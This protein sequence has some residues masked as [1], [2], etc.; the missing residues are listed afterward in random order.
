M[1]S[2]IYPHMQFSRNLYSSL[3]PAK[4][5]FRT[6]SFPDKSLVCMKDA[7]VG[8]ERQT[9][10]YDY[11]FRQ[12]QGP[13]PMIP[14]QD[15]FVR[16]TLKQVANQLGISKIK[17]IERKIILVSRKRSRLIMN[18]RELLKTISMVIGFEYSVIVLRMESYV[19]F[20]ELASKVSCAKILLGI[21]GSGL[22]LSAFLPPDAGL[23]ELFPYAVNP[24]DYTPYKTLAQLMSIPYRS[25][26]N[27]WPDKSITH[28]DYSPGLGGIKHL[29][30]EERERIMNSTQVPK[31]LCCDNSEWLYRINQDTIVDTQSLAQV[32][33]SLLDEM[34]EA[35]VAV[36]NDSLL[37]P[38]RV[39][40]LNCIRSGNEMTIKWNEPW[41]LRLNRLIEDDL[42][43]LS[44]EI[45][46]QDRTDKETLVYYSSQPMF[47]LEAVK[48]T[49]RLI[50]VRCRVK[51]VSGPFNSE[52]VYC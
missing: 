10:W 5:F 29:P 44:Y 38:G 31:H 6:D 49:Q 9:T 51:S 4:S 42:Q 1:T 35:A 26:S 19:N 16:K 7:F 34:K 36:K 13:L 33:Q 40:S 18:E 17:C 23:L 43:S 52:P 28:P 32:L 3:I 24:N 50:W 14:G 2:L 21:H 39:S 46:V 20:T 41:N 45:L 22:A 11:G 30:P 8:L 48:G 25:W 47:K 15:A 27:R 37:A 12:P